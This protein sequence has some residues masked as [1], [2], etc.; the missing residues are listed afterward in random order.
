MRALLTPLALMAALFLAGCGFTPMH[1]TSST[2]PKLADV[3]IDMKKVQ[4]VADNEAGFLITQRLRDRIG[5]ASSPAQYS[6]EII[7]KYRR[8]RLGLTDGDVASRYDVTIIASWQLIH[9][10][11]GK[12]AD[13]GQISTVSTFGAP[14][15]AYGVIT[16]DNV[17]VEQ[18]A[19]AT[20]D[21]LVIEIARSFAKE[22]KRKAAQLKQDQTP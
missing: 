17:G 13:R 19:K 11:T 8:S 15:G 2:S 10:R 14:I 9:A 20:A 12:V 4:N 3:A 18:A 22:E 7:P 21:K 1:A 6:L 16:A 5:V